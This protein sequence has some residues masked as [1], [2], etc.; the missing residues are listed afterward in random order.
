MNIATSTIQIKGVHACSV[1]RGCNKT[2]PASEA[3]RVASA[4]D[5]NIRMSVI[6]VTSV[7]DQNGKW[8]GDSHMAR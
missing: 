5:C 2:G 8:C 6:A 3:V 7:T 1:E 4:A